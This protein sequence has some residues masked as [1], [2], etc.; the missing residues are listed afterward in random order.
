MYV[1]TQNIRFIISSEFL[2]NPDSEPVDNLNKG[3]KANPKT[4]S[5]EAAKARDEVQPGHL[6]Q[7]REL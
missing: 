6:G 1:R 2:A 7:L 5:T 3:D 4:K